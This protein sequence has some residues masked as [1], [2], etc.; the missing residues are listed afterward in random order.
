M[1]TF[2]NLTENVQE[3][4]TMPYG[5]D[6][7]R[8]ANPE[9]GMVRYNTTQDALEFYNGTSWNVL[10]DSQVIPNIVTE[11]LVVNVNASESS[12]YSGATFNGNVVLNTSSPESFSW[13]SYSAGSAVNYLDSIPSL[14]T[15]PTLNNDITL[16]A[17]AKFDNSAFTSGKYH[18]ITSLNLGNVQNSLNIIKQSN[19]AGAGNEI[20]ANVFHNNTAY[21]AIPTSG[22][23]SSTGWFQVATVVSGAS[24]KLYFNA[25]LTAS[26]TI[27]SSRS[28]SQTTLEVGKNLSAPNSATADMYGEISIIRVYSSALSSTDITQNF[29]ATKTQFGL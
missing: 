24:L 25:N 21:Q 15:L 1:R 27:P 2:K 5:T 23:S 19:T 11:N 3:A 14:G 17:W 6:F 29:N 8:P 26:A 7:N 20:Y 13:P 22:I 4:I 18:Y 12:S 10:G 9:E 16:I 28:T